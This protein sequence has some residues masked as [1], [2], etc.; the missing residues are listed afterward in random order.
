[1]KGGFEGKEGAIEGWEVPWGRQEADGRRGQDREER[2]V[3]IKKGPW[4]Q[5][6]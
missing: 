1:V 4:G 3:G 6:Q 2:L 5:T